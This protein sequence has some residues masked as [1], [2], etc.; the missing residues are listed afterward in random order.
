MKR[1]RDGLVSRESSVIRLRPC[2]NVWTAPSA[3]PFDDGWYG[4]VRVCVIPFFLK[5][6][7][8]SS[9]VNWVPLSVTILSGMLC[10]AKTDLNFSIVAVNVAHEA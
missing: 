1:K 6:L 9:L 7:V 2:L 10:V 5:K 4:A 8:N 3:R